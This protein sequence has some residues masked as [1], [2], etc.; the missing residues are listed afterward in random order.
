M[1]VKAIARLIVDTADIHHNIRCGNF[2]PIAR[3]HHGSGWLQ[4]QERGSCEY[5]VRVK[6]AV[7]RNYSFSHGKTIS[8]RWR[9]VFSA[10]TG[11]TNPIGFW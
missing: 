1:V 7:V 10:L 2:S 9:L 11:P 8:Q 5:I 4:K 3:P 6:G